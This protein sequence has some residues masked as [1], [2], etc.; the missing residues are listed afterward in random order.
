[1]NASVGGISS[2]LTLFLRVWKM[3]C[4]HP[5]SCETQLFTT[6]LFF[7]LPLSLLP[8]AEYLYSLSVFLP[9]EQR[10][11][12][13]CV[14][15]GSWEYGK[16]MQCVAQVYLILFSKQK[17]L[18]NIPSPPLPPP[19]SLFLVSFQKKGLDVRY[20]PITMWVSPPKKKIGRGGWGE[21]G[22]ANTVRQQK[23]IEQKKTLERRVHGSG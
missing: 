6:H 4:K 13:V 1:M 19:F 5:L 18:G 23:L 3:K 7:F 2:D 20:W 9:K 16:W 15:L 8:V 17:R 10:A 14:E 21:E 22:C 12:L 11:C